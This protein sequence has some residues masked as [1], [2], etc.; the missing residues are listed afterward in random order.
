MRINDTPR[1]PGSSKIRSTYGSW[2]HPVR[3]H[4][5]LSISSKYVD[6]RRVLGSRNPQEVRTPRQVRTR[7]AAKQATK[8][9][10]VSFNESSPHNIA[11]MHE[12]MNNNHRAQ[13]ASTIVED[14]Q[15]EVYC[16]DCDFSTWVDK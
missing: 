14:G 2:L 12:E 7:L 5:P 1:I 6:L 9:D 3:Q 16:L 10:E 15:V 13:V 8:V 11:D 4:T